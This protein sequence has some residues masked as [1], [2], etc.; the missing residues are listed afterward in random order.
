MKLVKKVYVEYWKGVCDICVGTKKEVL[1]LKNIRY[2]CDIPA[3][4]FGK[5]FIGRDYSLYEDRETGETYACQL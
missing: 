2:V 5:E 4:E 1:P 3:E